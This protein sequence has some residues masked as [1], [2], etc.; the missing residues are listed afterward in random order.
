MMTGYASSMSITPRPR[1]AKGD[2]VSM[3]APIGGPTKDVIGYKENTR[4][5]LRVLGL[6]SSAMVSIDSHHV[7]LTFSASVDD[8]TCNHGLINVLTSTEQKKR[9]RC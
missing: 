8:D 2:R 7:P 1:A 3:N 9:G 4:N 5:R 6:V